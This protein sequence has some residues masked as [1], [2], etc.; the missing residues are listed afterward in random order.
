M[1]PGSSKLWDCRHRSTGARLRLSASKTSRS[2]RTRDDI[3]PDGARIALTG[4]DRRPCG[5]RGVRCAS[6][7]HI[8]AKGRRRRPVRVRL[9]RRHAGGGIRHREGRQSGSAIRWTRAPLARSVT[10]TTGVVFLQDLVLTGDGRRLIAARRCIDIFD[11]TRDDPRR[12]QLKRLRDNSGRFH[13]CEA[14]AVVGDKR[15]GNHCGR[16]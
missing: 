9:Q 16:G 12:W 7:E 3:Q 13:R 4:A 6:A 8:G 5:R 15:L 14:G 10:S 1:P 11:L 2:C